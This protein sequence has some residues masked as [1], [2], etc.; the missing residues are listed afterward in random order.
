MKKIYLSEEIKNNKWLTNPE[1]W[2]GFIHS[3]IESEFQRIEIDSNLTISKINR[4]EPISDELKSKFN[5]IVFS[6]LLA[7]ISNMIYFINDK[8]IVLNIA[9]E[10]IKK[11]DYKT[12]F[13]II[14]ND[15]EEI[16]KLR[17]EYNQ[18]SKENLIQSN[19]SI[20]EDKGNREEKIQKNDKEGKEEKK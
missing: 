11:Y 18:S 1:F 12:L 17:K 15:K 19:Q 2:K 3:M 13:G 20:E 14:S 9:D 7:H 5:D 16:E 6:Q 4:K 8:K 10:L